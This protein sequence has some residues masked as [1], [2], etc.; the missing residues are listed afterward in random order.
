MKSQNIFK[1]VL[2]TLVAFLLSFFARSK[3]KPKAVDLPN[4]DST[5]PPKP[6]PKLKDILTKLTPLA[7]IAN[8]AA[9]LKSL[10]LDIPIIDVVTEGDD[11]VITLYGGRIERFPLDYNLIIKIDKIGKTDEDAPTRLALSA[12]GHDK[13]S[14]KDWLPDVEAFKK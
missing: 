6:K 2:F 11:L 7:L 10:G 8:L 3:A 12:L 5:P 13:K 9:A 4:P 14:P 1:F